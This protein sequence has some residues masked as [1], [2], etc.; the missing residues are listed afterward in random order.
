MGPPRAEEIIR[1]AYALGADDGVLLTDRKMAGSDTYVTAGTLAKA[2][3]KIGSYDIIFCGLQAIDGDT[4][5]VGPQLAERLGI[6]QVTFVEEMTLEEDK[7]A[8]F[9]RIIE[10]GHEIYKTRNPIDKCPLLVTITNTANKPRI[11]SIMKLMKAKKQN[12]TT[13]T[14]DDLLADGGDES[15][16][17]MSGSP[18]RVKKVERP[19]SNKECCKMAEGKNT[20]E[21]VDC[22]FKKI[23]DDKVQIKGA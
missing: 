8:R 23:E 9:K 22:F 18:T 12:V 2:V 14:M 13:W 4:A 5:Q 11:P 1:E 17:G 16:Y 20:E 15:K 7:K 10:G 6:P 19:Q 21:L 3:E